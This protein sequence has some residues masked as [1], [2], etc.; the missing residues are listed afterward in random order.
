MLAG[1]NLSFRSPTVS[2]TSN[3]HTL[4]L[5]PSPKDNPNDLKCVINEGGYW[6][7]WGRE[8]VPPLHLQMVPEPRFEQRSFCTPLIQIDW[9]EW[10]STAPKEQSHRSP[11]GTLVLPLPA[12]ELRWSGE[13]RA[14]LASL[15]S[16]AQGGWCGPPQ[17]VLLLLLAAPPAREESSVLPLCTHNGTVLQPS[18]KKLQGPYSLPLR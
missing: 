16:L 14:S 5:S 15:A 11:S 7:G 4:P 12:W 1:L 17:S 13:K 9:A 10:T 18:P 6:V 2:I 8:S 3:T